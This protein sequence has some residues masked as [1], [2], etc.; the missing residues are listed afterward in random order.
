MKEFKR[1]EEQVARLNTE[2][3]A[4]IDLQNKKDRATEVR[5]QRKFKE[6][7]LPM[8]KGDFDEFHHWWKLF[9][10][11]IDKTD[12]LVEEKFGCLMNKLQGDAKTTVGLLQCSAAGYATAKQR[13]LDRYGDT[14]ATINSIIKDF[15]SLPTISKDEDI[16]GFIKLHDR[17]QK[18]IGTLDELEAPRVHYEHPTRMRLMGSLPLK[19]KI[20]WHRKDENK[21]LEGVLKSMS[22]HIC[23]LRQLGIKPK[24]VVE[25]N[26]KKSNNHNNNRHSNNNNNKKKKK[27]RTKKEPEG[28]N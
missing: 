26:K 7:S 5:N 6:S 24:A 18:A 1:L 9:V 14:Q 10:D 13:L 4:A 16:D 20:E 15:E 2:L 28:N 19:M 17:M 27:R 25:D 3:E 8:F 11:S 12:M 23:S 21:T 22:L